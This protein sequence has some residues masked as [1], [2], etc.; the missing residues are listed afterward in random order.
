MEQLNEG[1]LLCRQHGVSIQK[2]STCM[3]CLLLGAGH[4]DQRSWF[5]ALGQKPQAD[6]MANSSA[7]PR[8]S[9]T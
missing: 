8:R 6:P 3:S 7:K 9:M 1:Q 2:G 5:I 4:E